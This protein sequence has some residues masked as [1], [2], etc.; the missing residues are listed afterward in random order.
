MKRRWRKRRSCGPPE[1]DITAFMNLMV[2]LVPFLLISAVFSRITI[3]EL[4]L[5]APGAVNQQK[6]K[7]EPEKLQ[8]EVIVRKDVIEI[9]DRKGGLLKLVEV[10]ADGSH[11]QQISDLLQQVKARFPDKQDATLLLETDTAY[12]RL[13]AM[14]DT[15]RV[16]QIEQD[17]GMIT[18]ELFPV[19]S[20][21]D[22]PAARLRASKRSSK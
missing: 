10:E 20:I 12:E 9:G 15:L 14:M 1:L 22:A 4:D 2:I 18:A 8:L 16:A 6:D 11:L 21:G 17:D 3:L 19:I 5:P 7:D 13:V